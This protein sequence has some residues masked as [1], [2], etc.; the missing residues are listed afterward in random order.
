MSGLVGVRIAGTGR[1]TP[2]QKLTNAD[3]SKIVDTSDEWIVQRTG[4][5]ERR[6][7]DPAKGEQT[8]TISQWA[9]ERALKDSGTDPAELELV[10][11]A[12]VTGEMRCPATACV[13]AS[14]VG[15]V[16]AGAFDILAAC[17]GFVYAMQLA[18]DLI[19]CGS[20]KTVGV[21]GCDTMSKLL[22]FD[23]RGVCVLF[24]D[25]AG[26]AI[27]KATDDTSKGKRVGAMRSDGSGWKDLY[28]PEIDSDYP[29]GAS[30]ETNKIDTLQMNGRE[31]YKFAVGTFPRLIAETLERGNVTVEDVDMF[32]CHQSN[33]R[34][35]ESAREKFGIPHE[36]MYV[37]IDRYGNCSA[38]SVPLC[39]DELREQGKCQEGDL[40][41]FVAFG[42]G[43]TWA[44]LLWQ[45]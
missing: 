25:A 33:A 24:G 8:R 11:L 44:S 27:L 34:M 23:N 36:K 28:I 5:H 2:E 26:A 17:S 38:G 30:R 4:I 21:I 16:N 14:A 29:E 19:A 12:S 22:D 35:I 37:N 42:G 32:I 45:M 9:L 13:I 43:L 39:L 18:H 15:A 31:V 20:Y 40:V 6:I 7:C 1:Y 41:M 10:I 3:L